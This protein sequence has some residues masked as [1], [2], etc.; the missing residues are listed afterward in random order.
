[1]FIAVVMAC[2][3]QSS[4][5]A[6]VEERFKHCAGALQEK[7]PRMQSLAM[8]FRKTTGLTHHYSGALMYKGNFYFTDGFQLPFITDQIGSGDAFTAGMLYS[9]INSFEPQKIITFAAACGALKQ[10]I[11]GDW[12]IIS[13]DEIEQFI[14]SGASGRIIR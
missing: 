8:S 2:N 10:S 1:M 4:R 7:L 14:Q 9:I 6:P 3:N 5:E 12:P 13:K 11:A